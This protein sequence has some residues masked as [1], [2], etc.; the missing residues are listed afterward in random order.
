[1]RE[2]RYKVNFV[3]DATFPIAVYRYSGSIRHSDAMF[4]NIIL[5]IVREIPARVEHVL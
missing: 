2:L 3:E 4:T 5:D 1:M